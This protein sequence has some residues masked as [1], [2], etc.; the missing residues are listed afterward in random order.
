MERDA[1]ELMKPRGIR[2]VREEFEERKKGWDVGDFSDDQIKAA[3]VAAA[4]LPGAEANPNMVQ[5]PWPVAL[6]QIPAAAVDFGNG[7]TVKVR[8]GDLIATQAWLMRDTL[9]KHIKA[10]GQ[11]PGKLVAALGGIPMV[12]EGKMVIDGHHRLSAVWLLSGR[13]PDLKVDAWSMPIGLASG[14]PRGA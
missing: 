12:A 3:L 4:Q 1:L 14:H 8:L 13:N 5:V 6:T 10:K 7:D 2:I 11:P 9:I